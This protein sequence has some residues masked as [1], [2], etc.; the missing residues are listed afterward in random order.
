MPLRFIKGDLKQLEHRNFNL[1]ASKYKKRPPISAK[2]LMRPSG[3]IEHDF[4]IGGAYA[5][6]LEPFA[7]G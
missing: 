6:L 5:R 2:L 1:E 3:L 4:E 7:G